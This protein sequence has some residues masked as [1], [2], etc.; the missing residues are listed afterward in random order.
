MRSRP[1]I[2]PDPRVALGCSEPQSMLY[3]SAN[4]MAQPADKALASVPRIVRFGPFQVS[5]ETGELR[6]HGVRVRL[7]RRP[8]QILAALLERPGRLVTREELRRKLWPADVFVDFESG[9]N[10]AVNRLRLALGDVADDPTYIETLA[11]LG[12]RFLAP[13]EIV[14]PRP[15]QISPAQNPAPSAVP[16]PESASAAVPH[17]DVR[18]GRGAW[19]GNSWRA[20]AALASLAVLIATTLLVHGARH[21]VSFQRLTFR[22]GFITNARF[23]ADGKHIVYSAEWN[24]G[25]S[26]LYLVSR[27][28]R[29]SRDLKR[30]NTWLQAVSGAP[31][32]GILVFQMNGDLNQLARVTLDGSPAQVMAER[33]RDA[34]IGPDGKLCL[35]TARGSNYTIEYPAGH[36]LYQ[37]SAWIGDVRISRDGRRVAFAEHPILHDDAG[38]VAV[39]DTANGSKHVLGSGWASLLGLAWSASGTEVWFTAARSGAERSLMAVTLDGRTRLV[40]Q[41][42]GGMHLRDVAPSGEV[43]VDRSNSHMLMSSGNLDEASQQDISWLDWSRPV[44]I[45]ADGTTILFD[46][47]GTGGGAGYSVFLY[48]H[49][50]Q[51]PRQ[52]GSG[53]AMDLSDDEQWALAQDASDPTKL[54]LISVARQSAQAIQGHGFVYQWSKFIPR[55]QE[56]LVGGRFPGHGAGIYRQHLPDGM[57]ALVTSGVEF[58]DPV[59]D[60]TGRFA[61]GVSD[62]CEVTVVDLT[63]GQHRAVKAGRATYP[64]V[65]IDQNRALARTLADKTISLDFLDLRSGEASPFKKIEA[66]DMTGVS[67]LFPVYVA[68]NLN[69]YVY[70]RLETYSDLFLISGLT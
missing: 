12:Y 15:E 64:V 56:I 66:S 27:D 51:S 8:F 59:I 24:G 47:S 54:S 16:V 63:S 37:S 20:G 67:G 60:S 43:V 25:P 40:A 4:N 32:P 3:V 14:L 36:I 34:D 23:T 65:L 9:L 6:K 26:S 48:T 70:S 35:V 30:P 2:N 13:V 33:V 57:P 7:Q 21:N 49:H 38:Q 61:A 44:A 28:G 1:E 41:T 17:T 50:T 45:S 39:V 31:G 10:T 62:R 42:A 5:M 52:I 55:S 69:N 18:R 19:R 22:K 58:D 53:R 46:E 29:G 11:R 68:K